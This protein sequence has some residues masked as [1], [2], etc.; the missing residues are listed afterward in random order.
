[1]DSI[2]KDQNVSYADR[3]KSESVKLEALA[4]LRDAI[5]ASITSSDPHSALEKIIG[6][7]GSCLGQ[8]WCSGDQY[9]MS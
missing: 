4:M 6:K 9:K 1:M 7:S 5:E 2:A 3:V 8:C